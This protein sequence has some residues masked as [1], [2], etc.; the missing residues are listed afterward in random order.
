MAKYTIDRETGFITQIEY[1]Q[2]KD[3]DIVI[4]NIIDG[5]E[6]KGLGKSESE[7]SNATDLG[8]SIF[9][10]T[11]GNKSHPKMK[12][13]GLP[14]SVTH[15]NRGALMWLEKVDY[16][17]L[18]NNVKY[19]GQA[20]F[21]GAN[22]REIVLQEG[23]EYIG[24]YA[25]G[26]CYKLQ[27]IAIPTTVTYLGLGALN[28][29]L[30]LKS[31]TMPEG[32]LTHLPLRCIADCKELK[33]I[34]LPDT[35]T[36]LNERVFEGC[37]QLEKVT[38]PRGLKYL[39]AAFN[40]CPSLKELTI[41]S[42]V[43]AV[44]EHEYLLRGNSEGRA[45]AYYEG[46]EKEWAQIVEAGGGSYTGN[47]GEKDSWSHGYQTR[48]SWPSTSQETYTLYFKGAKF[49]KETG[50]IL[51]GYL[52]G[53]FVD[54]D[55]T[56]VKYP[57]EI[58]GI[59]VKC[60]KEEIF[61]YNVK[62]LWIPEGVTYIQTLGSSTLEKVVFP[63]SLTHIGQVSFFDSEKLSEITL[64]RGLKVIGNHVF[65]KIEDLTIYYEGTS[66][67]WEAVEKEGSSASLSVICLDTEEIE[68]P[69]SQVSENAFEDD[70][71]GFLA[72]LEEPAIS[73]EEQKLYD[74]GLSKEQV[75]KL[76]SALPK[77]Q[78]MYQNQ[79]LEDEDLMKIIY[80]DVYKRIMKK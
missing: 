43:E 63:K 10:D 27:S 66:V 23:V 76:D 65:E 16:L 46:S 22:I 73:E 49:D 52:S 34:C 68:E 39:G 19:I 31:V 21:L 61:P 26:G 69:V 36:Y 74:L 7:Y 79:G 51:S 78:E 56:V 4:P 45:V 30:E 13:L 40:N 32:G 8:E 3:K 44:E 58:L 55:S 15:I 71:L 6:V 12:S 59:S 75:Q 53:P 24:D 38:L 48:D 80:V 14:E 1:H 37:L 18:G 72:S 67:E 64:P 57:E 77:Y 41:P 54:K 33:E 25:F 50:T 11:Y 62:E 28:Q 70:I 47:Y 20:A 5:I 60:I 29:C 35:L 9:V 42:S 17:V 2:T